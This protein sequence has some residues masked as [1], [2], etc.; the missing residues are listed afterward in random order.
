MGIIASSLIP[1]NRGL[2]PIQLLSTIGEIIYFCDEY[3][4][5]DTN[6]QCSSFKDNA[7]ITKIFNLGKISTIK[8]ITEYNYSIVG[9]LNQLILVNDY[10]WKQFKDLTKDDKCILKKSNI[11]SSTINDLP[12]T[13]KDSISIDE[14]D[15]VELDHILEATDEVQ[16]AYLQNLIYNN[17]V[18]VSSFSEEERKQIRTLLLKFNIVV[19]DKFNIQENDDEEFMFL[20]ITDTIMQDEKTNYQ[21]QIEEGKS[22]IANGFILQGIT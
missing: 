22:F 14:I 17:H 20:T 8:I 18:D 2:L 13:I 15:Y 4:N 19:N 5:I 6:Y 16:Q 10:Q 21:L 11:H 12:F 7:T 1:T 3:Q 9:T